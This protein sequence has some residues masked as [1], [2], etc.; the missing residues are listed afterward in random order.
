LSGIPGRVGATPIQN[1]GA[2]GQDVSE[3]ITSVLAYDRKNH[4]KVRLS[5]A[6]C[7]FAYRDSYFK[8]HDPE[9]FVIS[10][11][12]F[13][14]RANAPPKLAYAELTRALG[15]QGATPPLAT[16]RD[17]VLALRR[18]KSMLI[19]ASDP[20]TRSCGSFFTNPTLSEDEFL[21]F[22]FR[23]DGEGDVPRFPQPDGRIKL[24][25]GWL[26]EHAGFERGTI[27][28][29]VGLSERHA[30]ALIARDGAK[31]RDVV[32]FARK[33]RSTV[34]ER[35]GVKLVPEPVFW[36]FPRMEQGLPAPA[37]ISVN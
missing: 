24:S 5:S 13:R 19:D 35:F 29:R 1:V 26:I 17:T 23:A 6:D 14:L 20:N 15:A 21:R 36:G 33:I 3:T 34:L 32:A 11:V 31:A 16:V 12:V 22:S 7:R 2:Y 28:G 25:A 30:L 10:D 9:R 8:S 4:V 18:S 27:D 37:P